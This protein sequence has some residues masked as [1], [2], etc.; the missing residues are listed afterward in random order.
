M[1]LL[2]D[3]YETHAATDVTILS[4]DVHVADIGKLEHAS[5]GV[6]WQVTSSGIGSPPPDG[7]AGWLMEKVSRPKID[8]GAGFC[9]TLIPITE[10]GHD[11]MNRRNFALL[12]LAEQNAL[13][14]KLFG[15][16][17]PEPRE[18]VLPKRR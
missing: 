18:F 8:L 13:H 17:L 3:F 9:G 12:E 16:G 6:T 10:H 1:E 7:L 15:E 11:L 4:G 14:V 2:L 5:A